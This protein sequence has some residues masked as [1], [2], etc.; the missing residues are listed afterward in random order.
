MLSNFWNEWEVVKI[1]GE[2]GYSWVWQIRPKHSTEYTATLKVSKQNANTDIQALKHP[3]IA[4]RN[5]IKA[6]SQLRQ[7]GLLKRADSII[8]EHPEEK[9]QYH[10]ALLLDYH[11]GIDLFE[12]ADDWSTREERIP[13]SLI[14]K[15][16]KQCCKLL[17]RF[18]NEFGMINGDVKPENIIVNQ[19][20][21]KLNIAFVDFGFAQSTRDPLIS[22]QIGTIGYVAPEWLHRNI[23][24][25]KIVDGSLDIFS[26][27]STLI[28]LAINEPAYDVIDGELVWADKIVSIA[29]LFEDDL[30]LDQILRRMVSTYPEFRPTSK[31]LQ[32][33]LK[34]K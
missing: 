12:W 17:D 21:T 23:D 34:F 27:G 6:C 22:S 26:L 25:T 28:A 8:I 13:S 31:E 7:C 29:P 33:L 19:I 1:L 20:G 15:I 14:R 4:W 11:P 16:L 18:H 24:Y 5:E 2:G 10:T 30:K 3:N 32:R 9:G